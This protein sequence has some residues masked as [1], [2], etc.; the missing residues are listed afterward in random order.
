VQ[1][2]S[3]TP[4]AFLPTSFQTP[5]FETH[6]KFVPARYAPASLLATVADTG[7]C[8]RLHIRNAGNL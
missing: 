7:A 2:C 5:L 6:R 3:I 4:E 8:N 1:C